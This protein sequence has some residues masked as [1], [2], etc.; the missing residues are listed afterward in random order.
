MLQE[1]TFSTIRVPILYGNFYNPVF[2]DMHYITMSPL[3][4]LSKVYAYS[5]DEAD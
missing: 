5:G 3:L 4:K 1:V 2:S